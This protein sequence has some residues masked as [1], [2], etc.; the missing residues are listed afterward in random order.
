MTSP[1]AHRGVH[2]R[3]GAVGQVSN[4]VPCTNPHKLRLDALARARL[5]APS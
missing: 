3:P 4:A 1:S 2:W 5:P